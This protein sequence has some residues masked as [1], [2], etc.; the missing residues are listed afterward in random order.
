VAPLR[1]LRRHDV[2]ETNAH[3]LRFYPFFMQKNLELGLYPM[4]NADLGQDPGCIIG[5]TF[6]LLLLGLKLD[7]E[8]GQRG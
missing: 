4:T 1:I 5:L 6:N 3:L 8:G 2:N 7:A